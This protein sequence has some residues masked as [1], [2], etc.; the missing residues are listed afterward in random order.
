MSFATGYPL[1]Q[2]RVDE[3]NSA[4]NTEKGGRRT[5]NGG[6]RLTAGKTPEKG[7]NLNKVRKNSQNRRRYW[8]IKDK[9]RHYW[10]PE[11]NRKRMS[12]I[13]KASL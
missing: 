5:H 4:V 10:R 3:A 12:T 6:F 2:L 9:M 7:Y 1:H 8:G 13:V 11:D